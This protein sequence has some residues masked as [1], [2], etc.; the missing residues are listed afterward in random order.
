M[1][2]AQKLCDYVIILNTHGVDSREEKDFLEI[3]K[4]ENELIDLCII[5]KTLKKAL[6]KHSQ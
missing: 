3:H 2:Q 1:T 5:S 4:E 6:N